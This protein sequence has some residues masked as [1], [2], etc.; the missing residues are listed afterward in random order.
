MKK[1]EKNLKPSG[2][3]GVAADGEGIVFSLMKKQNLLKKSFKPRH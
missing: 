1:K 3:T 2:R